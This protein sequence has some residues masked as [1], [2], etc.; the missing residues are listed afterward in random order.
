M[1]ESGG[2]QEQILFS[3]SIRHI[4]KKGQIRRI[5]IFLIKV[6]VCYIQIESIVLFSATKKTSCWLENIWK[7]NS[8]SWKAVLCQKWKSKDLRKTGLEWTSAEVYIP[9]HGL[10]TQWG[11]WIISVRKMDLFMWL[12]SPFP[13]WKLPPLILEE[14]RA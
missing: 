10:S 1:T 14:G 2:T 9:P 6:L 4:F 7:Q 13:C 3:L 12:L 8:V 11:G 5:N